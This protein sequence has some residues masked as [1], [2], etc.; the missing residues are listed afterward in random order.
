VLIVEKLLIVMASPVNAD[1]RLCPFPK[2][3]ETTTMVPQTANA[4]LV[5]PHS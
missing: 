1:K 5:N 2:E 3:N 4:V